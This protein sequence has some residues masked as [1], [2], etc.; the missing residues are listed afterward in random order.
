MEREHGLELKRVLGRAVRRGVSKRNRVLGNKADDES[1]NGGID[2]SE[3][4][5]SLPRALTRASERCGR[6]HK[7]RSHAN[8]EA[9]LLPVRPRQRCYVEQR[10]I[11]ELG[12][13]PAPGTG[14]RYQRKSRADQLSERKE[15]SGRYARNQRSQDQLI[16]LHVGPEI[17]RRVAVADEHLGQGRERIGELSLQLFLLLKVSGGRACLSFSDTGKGNRRP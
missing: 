1:G 7:G 5:A 9:S 10:E 8:Q 16:G 2:R 3:R 13:G 6:K 17:R 15:R 12:A 11:A 4:W 14:N